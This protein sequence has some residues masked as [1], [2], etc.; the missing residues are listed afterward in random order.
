MKK[1]FDKMTQG[2]VKLVEKFLPDPYIFAI[3]LTFFVVIISLIVTKTT[4]LN[5]IEAWYGGFWSLLTFSMQMAMILVTGTIL[6]TAPLFKKGLGKLASIPKNKIQAIIWV[7]VIGLV[8]SFINWG[9][10]L[11][12]GAIFAKEVAKRVKGVD[13]PLLVAAAYSG[14]LIWH[15]GLSGSIPLT[16]ATGG[17]TLVTQTGGAVVDAISTSQTI[18]SVTNLVIVG[19]I[20]LTLPILLALMHPKGDKV[21]TVD[22]LLLEDEPAPV[23]KDRKDMTPAEKLENSRVINYILAAMGFTFIVMY[24]IEKGFDLNLNIVIFIFLFAAIALHGTPIKTVHAVNSAAKSVGGILLQF[25]FYAGIMGIMTAKGPNDISLAG[26]ISDLFVN[27]SN[28]TT[29][30]L[31]TFLSAGIVNIFVPSGGGQWAVQGPIMMPAGLAL[32]V[33]PAKTA[34][35]IAWGDAWT[36]MIQPFWALPVLGIAK[37]GAKNIM[38]YCLMVLLYSGVIIGLGLLL[39]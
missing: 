39:I 2:S 32:G 37:L 19:V 4:P 29:F 30:P 5:I 7:S 26:A 34:M 12:I 28:G 20:I 22:P 23:M 3:L 8:A 6:A 11:V 24:F 15:A 13:Y 25:P 9:F 33:E 35:A 16:L 18:F 36:N 10:G 31:F 21:K 27:I 14:F 1:I 38:G 17:A